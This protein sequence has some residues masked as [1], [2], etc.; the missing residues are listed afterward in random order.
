MLNASRKLFT[1]LSMKGTI[2]KFITA[3]I[4]VADVDL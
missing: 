3:I 2:N 1:T 4:L